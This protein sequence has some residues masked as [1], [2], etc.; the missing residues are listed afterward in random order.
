MK[1][2]FIALSV[3]C[4]Y[5]TAITIRTKRELETNI[6]PYYDYIVVG[7]GISGLVVANRLSEDPDG[8]PPLSCI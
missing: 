6:L 1:L 8:E 5:T 7:A 3:F 2:S 4:L